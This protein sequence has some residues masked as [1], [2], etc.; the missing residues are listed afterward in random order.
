VGSAIWS[1]ARR[2][3]YGET[4][5]RLADALGLEADGRTALLA[6]GHRLRS[7]TPTPAPAEPSPGTFLIG[8]ANL[9]VRRTVLIG[10]DAEVQ[11][12]HG[13]VL[14]VEGRLVTLT[15][16]GGCGKTSLGLEV[17]RTLVDAFPDGV[18]LVE[19]APLADPA[20]VPQAVASLLGVR[21]GPE[22]PL[23]DGLIAYLEPRALLV[24]LD[25][26]EHLVEAC[27]GLTERLLDRCP[28]LR[29]L[30]TSRE[31]LG[32][33]GEQTWRV[34]S[35]AV[36]DRA[37]L[38]PL[39]DLAAVPAVG[40]FVERARRVEPAFALSER[41][42]GAVAEVCARLGGLPLAPPPG[43]RSCPPR[44]WWRVVCPTARSARRW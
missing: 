4:V 6:A 23:L 39:E 12:V 15:G 5:R 18:W 7:S 1:A 10:R 33:V 3:P 30:A 27:A 43:S 17:A 38:P 11:T 19:P 42:A 9:P 8:R 26:C 20:L 29:I 31:P 22:R 35:L 41:N 25:N 36:P 14:N 21:E 44:R 28:E 16:A 24:V 32:L 34:P 2:F 37:R 40:L 13:L